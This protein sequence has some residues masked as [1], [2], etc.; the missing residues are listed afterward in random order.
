MELKYT[1]YLENDD[2]VNECTEHIQFI[3]HFNIVSYVSYIN[4]S[5]NFYYVIMNIV[6][7]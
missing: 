3:I 1:M 7:E 5:E 2:E 4:I 6:N